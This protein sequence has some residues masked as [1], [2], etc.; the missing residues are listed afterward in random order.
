M[1]TS[2][3]ITPKLQLTAEQLLTGDCWIPPKTDTLC[4][5]AKE[6]PQQDS[7]RGKIT[8]RI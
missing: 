3:Q 1:Q 4:Q 7:R 6:K 5:R 2:M 8:F